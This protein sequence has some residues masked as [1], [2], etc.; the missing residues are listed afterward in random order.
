MKK[1]S[2]MVLVLATLLCFGA[3][4][5]G[6]GSSSG[7][8]VSSNKGSDDSN[9]EIVETTLETTT[10][11]ATTTV[12]Y[13][14]GMDLSTANAFGSA[15]SYLDFMGFSRDGLID[16][17]TS[18][19]GDGY[20]QEQAETAIEALEEYGLVDWNE[21]AVR[22]AQSYLDYSGFSRAGLI[23]QLSSEYGGQFTEEEATYA[24]DYL[25]ENG[26]VDWNEQAVR[27]AESYLEF[28]TFSRQEMIDQLSSE[29]GEQFTEEQAIYACDQIGLT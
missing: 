5:M 7:S 29:Y 28:S 23:D 21:Q 2:T 6:S 20:T 17:L 25:E 10:T 14:A 26:L 15:V 9:E 12:D 4:A 22:S 19:Y 3:F 8:S 16:Q 11:E 13:T 27:C 24:V 18:E 1:S